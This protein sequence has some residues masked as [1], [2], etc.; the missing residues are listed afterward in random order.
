MVSARRS[1][2]DI[3]EVRLDRYQKLIETSACAARFPAGP[4]R[5]GGVGPF[6]FKAVLRNRPGDGCGAG[7]PPL[8]VTGL[9]TRRVMKSS[10]RLFMERIRQTIPCPRRRNTPAG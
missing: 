1:L 9:H 6:R 4:V 8:N 3:E 7:R 10:P 2:L 5:S